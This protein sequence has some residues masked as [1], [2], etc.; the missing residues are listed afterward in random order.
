VLYGSFIEILLGFGHLIYVS[1]GSF[2][3]ILLGFYY[4]MFRMICLL[5]FYWDFIT[6]CSYGLFIEILLGFLSP[7]VLY[8][9][10]IEI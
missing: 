10:F 9:S 6:L 3:E 4:P 8:G 5:R 2:I 7:Y 1:Y